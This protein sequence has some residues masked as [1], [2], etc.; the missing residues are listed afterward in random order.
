MIS[1]STNRARL[2]PLLL[3][4]CL[5]TPA[6]AISGELAPYSKLAE[7]DFSLL[8]LNGRAHTL[9]DYRGKVVLVNFW[10]TWCPPCIHEMPELQKLKKHFAGRPF[11]I[12]TIN[13][14]EQKDRVGK[15]SRSIKLDLPVLLDTSSKTYR[16]WDVS[17]L[18]TSFLIDSKGQIRYRARGNPGW[19]E[20][21]TL[22]VIR[23]MM[24]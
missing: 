12:V 11:E 19:D 6:A 1:F 8:D 21:E 14:A 10:A 4:G 2:L 18:P 3:L 23:A 7:A 13:V 22:S 9:S 24:P 15:F 20:E 5:L 17:I 16:S